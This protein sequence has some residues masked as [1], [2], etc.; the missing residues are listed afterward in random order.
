VIGRLELRDA[1][2]RATRAIERRFGQSLM[3][4]AYRWNGAV[5][6]VRCLESGH[7]IRGRISKSGRTFRVTVEHDAAG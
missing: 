4:Y 5:L 3:G 2:V 6:T 7:F 1:E